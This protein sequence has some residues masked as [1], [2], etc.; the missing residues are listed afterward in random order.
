MMCTQSRNFIDSIS[1]SL[2]NNVLAISWVTDGYPKLLHLKCNVYYMLEPPAVTAH[3]Y[4]Q[5]LLYL[6]CPSHSV[7][8]PYTSSSK[9]G[10]WSGPIFLHYLNCIGNEPTLLECSS[11]PHPYYY[12]H[13][14]DAGVQCEHRQ[15]SGDTRS[16]LICYSMKYLIFAPPP[17]THTHTHILLKYTAHTM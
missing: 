17:H 6:L 7:A 12:S 5:S 9:F 10:A 14:R 13:Q 4:Y 2:L 3:I 11:Y 8:Y 1:R 15:Y 16:Q